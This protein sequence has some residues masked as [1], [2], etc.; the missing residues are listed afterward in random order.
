MRFFFLM[1]TIQLSLI[2]HELSVFEDFFE[3]NKIILSELTISRL[4]GFTNK[5]FLV[6]L[7]GEK[8]VFR[9]PGVQTFSYINRQTEYE[10]TLTARQFGFY[11]TDVIYFNPRTGCQISSFVT[12]SEPLLWEDF[13]QPET[14]E[15]A[16]KFLKRLHTSE[17]SFINRMDPFERIHQIVAMLEEKNWYLSNDYRVVGALIDDLKQ[18]LVH[19]KFAL[20]PCHN[21]PVPSNYVIV[22]SQIAMFDWE[23]SG[24]NDP[25]FDLAFLAAVMDYSDS[26]MQKMVEIYKSADSVLL[27]AKLFLYKPIVEYWLGLWAF[28]EI[29]DQPTVEEKEFF[30]AFSKARLKKCKRY[31]AD[32]GFSD[33]KC[34]LNEFHKMTS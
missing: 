31:M 19:E 5:N 23:H 10:N 33:A 28:A 9:I 13:Y 21:D 24:M 3:S 11:P 29:L 17:I 4:P 34:V 1:L 6:H 12:S 15:R 32:P 2:A 27:L 7:N 16:V 30:A 26:Q 18:Q 20:A 22:N 14:I 8:Y 25:A